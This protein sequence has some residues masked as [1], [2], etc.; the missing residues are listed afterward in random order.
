MNLRTLVLTA[1]AL[2]FVG[3]ASAHVTPTVAPSTGEVLEPLQLEVAEPLPIEPMDLLLEEIMLFALDDR[4]PE[5]SMLPTPTGPV[6]RW[7]AHEDPY[8]PVTHIVPVDEGTSSQ[9]STTMV[10]PSRGSFKKVEAIPSGGS[11]SPVSFFDTPSLRW[12]MTVLVLTF[13]V[14]FLLVLVRAARRKVKH[15]SLLVEDGKDEAHRLRAQVL[16]F[17]MESEK[18]KWQLA[19]SEEEKEGL[20]RD[21]I[22]KGEELHKLLKRPIA[23]KRSAKAKTGKTQNEG[24]VGRK[25]KAPE[26]GRADPPAEAVH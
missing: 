10:F 15:L 8:V 3:C 9:M 21:L 5:A 16:W 14:L 11:S 17:K 20:A 18:L 25:K 2:L 19:H 1:V 22:Q 6:V 13:S 23:R 24:R 4:T 7:F 26:K 12:A